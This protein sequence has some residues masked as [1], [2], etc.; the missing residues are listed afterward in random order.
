MIA[1]AFAARMMAEVR[2]HMEQRAGFILECVIADMFPGE[3]V[4]LYGR[5]VD[6]E[7][8]QERTML[9]LEAATATDAAKLGGITERHARRLRKRG[10][11]GG[12]TTP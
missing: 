1:Q 5:K 11:I 7:H 4:E 10:R 12:Q 3:S 2:F 8:R 6:P 9:V